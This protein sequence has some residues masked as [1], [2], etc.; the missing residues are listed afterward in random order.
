V[1]ETAG[2]VRRDVRVTDGWI[3]GGRNWQAGGATEFP[4]FSAGHGRRLPRELR[5]YPGVSRC[6]KVFYFVPDLRSRAFLGE[7]NV[8]ETEQAHLVIA[9]SG[10]QNGRVITRSF[11]FRQIVRGGGVL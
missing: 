7:T 1:P 9:Q 6:Y 4:W 3:T 10:P 8:I 2:D 11:K 5:C